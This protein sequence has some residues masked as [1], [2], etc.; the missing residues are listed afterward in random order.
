MSEEKEI[1]KSIDVYPKEF[2]PY[3]M[4]AHIA[5]VKEGLERASWIAANFCKAHV[6]TCP[7]LDIAK[8]IIEETKELRQKAGEQS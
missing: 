4:K 3:F 8:E 2:E 6:Y 5:G 7:C 1:V